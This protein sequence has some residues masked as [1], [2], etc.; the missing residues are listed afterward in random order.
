MRTRRLQLAADRTGKRKHGFNCIGLF[1][2]VSAHAIGPRAHFYFSI[3]KKG[4]SLHSGYAHHRKT[5]FEYLKSKRLSLRFEMG[6][7][8]IFNSADSFFLMRLWIRFLFDEQ[9]KEK[10][11]KQIIRSMILAWFIKNRNSV[12]KNECELKLIT[13]FLFQNFRF[14]IKRFD[15][16]VWYFSRYEADQPPN[17]ISMRV[18]VILP[19]QFGP[20]NSDLES[21]ILGCLG[22]AGRA[23]I[24]IHIKGVAIPV[25]ENDGLALS[26]I[27]RLLFPKPICGYACLTRKNSKNCERVL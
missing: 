26:K 9:E 15:F 14:R 19:N 8:S 18:I 21:K 4:Q 24:V 6:L 27:S 16:R 2:L 23:K 22:E 3:S 10:G 5:L 13:Y 1:S 12:R 17:W 11:K 25:L 7:Q 20:L